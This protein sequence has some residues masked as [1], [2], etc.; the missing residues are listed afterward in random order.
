MKLLLTNRPT[1]RAFLSAAVVT[2][3]VAS[4]PV[5]LSAQDRVTV[6]TRSSDIASGAF[7]DLNNGTIYVRVSLND[8]RKI[9]L[10]SILVFDFAGNGQNLPEAELRDAR[11]DDHLLVMRS[12]SRSRGRL[13]NIEGGEGSGK[14]GE[15]RII[16]FRT[17][18]G[19]ERRVRPSEVTRIYMGRY[20]AAPTP[21]PT[22]QPQPL[23]APQPDPA[24]PGLSV[25]ASQRWTP[26]GF[27]VQ[28]GQMVRF[29]ATGKVVLSGDN[30]DAATPAGSVS[31]RYAQGAPIPNI[32]AGALIARIG[33]GMPFGIGNQ[34]QALPMPGSGQLFLGVNDDN[35]NDNRGEFRVQVV[36]EGGGRRR[37]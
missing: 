11:G 27:S 29:S 16:S 2:C 10:G 17:V 26:T 22:P 9:P 37:Q 4:L 3:A 35:L 14:P 15:P 12:G 7:E 32:L 31:G 18:D 13:L 30:N 21:Q 8:Q 5:A 28:Q 20:P 6:V 19:E 25:P 1:A 34:A 23:P 33:N 24:G 36:P